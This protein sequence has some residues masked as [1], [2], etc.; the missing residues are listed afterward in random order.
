MRRLVHW[1]RRA[2]R[3]VTA[4]L[5]ALPAVGSTA[6]PASAGGGATVYAH[7]STGSNTAFHY[8][9]FDLQGQFGSVTV[10]NPGAF[11]LVTHNWNPGGTSGSLDAHPL[12]VWYDATAGDWSVFNQDGAAMPTNAS[13]NVY[14][15][16]DTSFPGVLIHR[17][18]PSNSAFDYTDIDSP[19]VNGNP[20][21]KVF[22]TQSYNPGGSG[23]V[24]DS[25]PTGVWYNAGT[26]HWSIFQENL[27]A[28]PSG[29]AFN[30]LA[31]PAP[32]SF[33]V[34]TVFVHTAT[35]SNT[36]AAYTC[37]NDPSLNGNPKA[38]AFVTQNYNPGGSGGVLDNA[39]VALVYVSSSWCIVNTTGVG[40]PLGASF[41]VM[42][43][44]VPLGTYHNH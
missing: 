16:A 27:S 29:A 25:S 5:L 38:L 28:V 15:F 30:V 31:A 21:A 41:N 35:K 7:T 17:A 44:S 12:G 26:G 18:T 13:F 40:V 32:G 2:L 3:L 36:W 39:P 6:L 22:V 8:T 23:G 4:A 1:R 14:E 37:L 43:S 10:G 9:V 24:A 20:N 33:G 34:A 42:V 11:V 19:A